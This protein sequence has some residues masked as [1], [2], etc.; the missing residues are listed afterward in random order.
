MQII[1]K[2]KTFNFHGNILLINSIDW[3]VSNVRKNNILP[4]VQ[5]WYDI[6]VIIDFVF[7]LG[8]KMTK[9]WPSLDFNIIRL[10]WHKA[11]HNYLLNTKYDFNLTW[12]QT[13]GSLESVSL[14]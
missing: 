14:T 10:Q 7:D 11:Q 1:I 8:H 13:R 5:C 2:I 3:Q 12:V 9:M 6:C 4:I